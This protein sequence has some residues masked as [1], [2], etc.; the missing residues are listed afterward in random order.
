MLEAF[1]TISKLDV[2]FW[3]LQNVN[4][5]SYYNMWPLKFLK[6]ELLIETTTASAM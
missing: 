1:Q 3:D 5:G 6:K 4:L 2:S